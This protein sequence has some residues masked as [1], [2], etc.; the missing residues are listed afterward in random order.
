MAATVSVNGRT[1]VHAG[2]EGVSTAF[3][4]A[5]VMPNGVVVPCFNTACSEDVVNCAETV[6]ADGFPV[7][8]S[9]SWFDSSTGNE[10]TLGGVISGQIK[11]KASFVNYSTNVF[12]EGKP[13]P[14]NG[15]PMVHNHGSPPNAFSPALV[16]P[17]LAGGNEKT[18]LCGVYCFCKDKGK[19]YCAALS[20]AEPRWV[21]GS[22][23]F[24]KRYWEPRHPKFYV[25]VPF[26]MSAPGGPAPMI[27][28]TQRMAKPPHHPL[29]RADFPPL[30]GTRR[31]DGVIVRN[32]ALPLS[33]TNVK[34]V[35]EFKFPGDTWRENGQEEAYKEIDPGLMVLDEKECGAQCKLEE[36][37]REPEPVRDPMRD[38]VRDLLLLALLAKKRLATPKLRPVPVGPLVPV[39]TAA[40]L[41]ALLAL[42]GRTLSSPVLLL[43][44]LP[45]GVLSDPTAGKET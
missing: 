33:R 41:G 24:P 11:G 23:L 43:P 6:F 25:E 2:S 3:P 28:E 1:V 29:P 21:R 35:F 7:A 27:D 20:I 36:R 19:T 42:F 40:G 5:C 34:R 10:A 13:V 45:P 8:T 26:D 22:K 16:Q 14:R 39:F 18:I 30:A 17:D 37:E 9:A 31:P 15:D 12:V 4:D 32:P 38:G 44:V